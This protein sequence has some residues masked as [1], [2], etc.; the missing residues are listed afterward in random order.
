MKRFCL[1]LPQLGPQSRLQLSGAII[2]DKHLIVRTQ[3]NNMTVRRPRTRRQQLQ[4]LKAD[5]QCILV[6][7]VNWACNL[8]PFKQTYQRTARA[9]LHLQHQLLLLDLV[10][11][12]VLRPERLL[13]HLLPT[14]ARLPDQHQR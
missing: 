14:M 3:D 5:L 11:P 7:W 4:Q 10:V 6:E 9:Q 2:H 13:D 1:H 8:P 12:S